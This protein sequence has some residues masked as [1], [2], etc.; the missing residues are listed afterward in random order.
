M[1]KSSCSWLRWTRNYFGKV[2]KFCTTVAI[3]ISFSAKGSI[4]YLNQ[5]EECAIYIF[6]S[7]EYNGRSFS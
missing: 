3:K 1:G 7:F 4:S 5:V 2:E 6:S